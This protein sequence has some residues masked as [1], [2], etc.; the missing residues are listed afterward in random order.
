[1]MAH[2]LDF[3]VLMIRIYQNIV[4]DIDIRQHDIDIRHVLQVDAGGKCG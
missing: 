3:E 2:K 1:M 4:Y